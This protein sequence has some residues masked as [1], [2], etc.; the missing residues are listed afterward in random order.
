MKA[1]PAK[2]KWRA[3]SARHLWEMI[4]QSAE[5]WKDLAKKVNDQGNAIFQLQHPVAPGSN[6]VVSNQ[7]AE[8]LTP[9]E[10]SMEQVCRRVC[11]INGHLIMSIQ[12][13]A[14]TPNTVIVTLPKRIE[15]CQHCGMTLE[16]IRTA[17]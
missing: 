4:L 17:K 3:P 2:G 8:V 6:R 5:N 7:A 1:K 10:S 12:E 16:E 9:K 11:H 13:T 14:M 15:F